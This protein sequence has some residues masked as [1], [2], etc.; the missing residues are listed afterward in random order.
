MHIGFL[1]GGERGHNMVYQELLAALA[2]HVA[3][4]AAT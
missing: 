1:L 4:P 2:A 3:K